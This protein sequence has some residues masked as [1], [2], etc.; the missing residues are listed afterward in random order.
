[1]VA[2]PDK[3]QRTSGALHG[4]QGSGCSAAEQTQSQSLTP[5]FYKDTAKSHELKPFPLGIKILLVLIA[6][7]LILI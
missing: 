5:G 7:A 2:A 1:M 3:V 4:S 6:A